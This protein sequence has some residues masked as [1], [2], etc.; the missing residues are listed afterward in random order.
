M[1]TKSVKQQLS[2]LLGNKKS[3]VFYKGLDTD[4]DEHVFANDRFID[5]NNIRINNQN[6]GLGSAQSIKSNVLASTLTTTGVLLIQ[7]MLL[8]KWLALLLV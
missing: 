7:L 1:S 3:N 6:S 5:A 4:T 2:E 8:Q